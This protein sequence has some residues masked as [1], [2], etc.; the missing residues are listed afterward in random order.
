VKTYQLRLIYH[1]HKARVKVNIAISDVLHDLENNEQAVVLDRISLDIDFDRKLSMEEAGKIARSIIARSRSMYDVTPIITH[2]G[3]H[4]IHVTYYLNDLVPAK[5]AGDLKLQV[6]EDLRLKELDTR[7]D[8]HALDPEHLFR[9][10]LTLNTKCNNEA[11]SF[12]T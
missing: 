6:Y 10:L 7:L 9:L 5:D 4:G 8:K 11:S 12:T 3:C 2:S 1:A